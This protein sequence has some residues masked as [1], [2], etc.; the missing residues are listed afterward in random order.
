MKR[1]PSFSF[2]TK[3]SARTMAISAVVLTVLLLLTV[4]CK[5]TEEEALIRYLE[6]RERTDRSKQGKQWREVDDFLNRRINASP[7]L[8]QRK[9]T[10]AVDRALSEY[11]GKE[12]AIVTMTSPIVLE[13]AAKLDGTQ[14]LILEQAI[15]YELDNGAMGIRGA[16]TKPWPNEIVTVF[17]LQDPDQ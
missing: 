2:V 12:P 4:R 8:L 6:I 1:L 11:E 10:L 9:I 13:K 3:L 16:W 17:P 15:Y 5:I 14:R 7:K